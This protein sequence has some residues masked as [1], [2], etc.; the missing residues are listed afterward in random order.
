MTELEYIKATNLAKTRSA[1]AVLKDV[2]PMNNR[3]DHLYSEAVKA[4]KNLTGEFETLL[5]ISQ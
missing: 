3:Q 2:L 5:K 1:Y 4:M